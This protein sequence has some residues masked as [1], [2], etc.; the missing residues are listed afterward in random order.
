M[1]ITEIRALAATFLTHL[2][3]PEVCK[4]RRSR[5]AGHQAID[6]QNEAE[7]AWRYL[8]DCKIVVNERMFI[9]EFLTLANGKI[10]A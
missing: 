4:K 6:L 7:A 3:H 5:P 9:H 1:K 2:E 10:Y 8:R